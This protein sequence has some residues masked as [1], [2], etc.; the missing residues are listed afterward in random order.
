MSLGQEEYSVLLFQV[1]LK[2]TVL[3]KITLLLTH[4]LSVILLEETM[5]WMASSEGILRWPDKG[6]KRKP[7]NSWFHLFSL[8]E[9]GFLLLP[10]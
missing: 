3:T 1:E 9:M 5:I 8:Y 4:F 10:Y 6:N 7:A 2:S